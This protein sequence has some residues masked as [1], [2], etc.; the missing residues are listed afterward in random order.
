MKS[1]VYF[2]SDITNN[3]LIEIY[4]KL[5][6]ELKGN[7]GVKISTGESGGHNYLKPLLI[8]DLIQYLNGTI[9]ECNTAYPGS[10][11][12]TEAHLKTIKEHGFLDIAKCDILDSSGEISIRVN[13][14]FHLKENIVGKNIENYDSMLVLSHFK[15][16]PMGGFGGALKNMSIGLASSRGKKLIHNAGKS[17]SFDSMFKTESSLF[18]ES[19]ADACKSIVDYMGKNNIIYINVL[20]NLSVDCDCFANP[21]DPKMKDIG[22]LASTDPVAL[23]MASV[24]LIYNSSDINKDSLIK[25]IESVDG[26][27]VILASN[28]LG[29][30]LVEYDLIKN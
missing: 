6:V 13:D 23:D 12:T 30:G 19:M 8:K 21:R 26:K 25:R 5:G 27:G 20:N 17:D 29:L 15:G 18:L 3:S 4:K 24:D 28:K 7:I 16:H 22:I 11:N 1:K 10:R 9:I 2:V 14:G